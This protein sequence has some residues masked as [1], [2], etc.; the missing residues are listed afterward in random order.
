ML[1]VAGT[2]SLPGGVGATGTSTALFGT[3]AVT[4]AATGG[5]V[6]GAGDGTGAVTPGAA[7]FNGSPVGGA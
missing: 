7:G 4:G 2:I 3:G 1:E 5:A 6:T